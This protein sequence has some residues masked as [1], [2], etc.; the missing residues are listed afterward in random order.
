MVGP[1]D[2]HEVALR[3][4]LELDPMGDGLA[5]ATLATLPGNVRARLLYVRGREAGARGL[6]SQD[7]AVLAHRE[8]PDALC[9]CVCDGVGSSY[10]GGFAAQF[11]ARRIV[12]WL[13]VLDTLVPARAAATLARALDAWAGEAHLALPAV[14]PSVEDS[15]P[16]VREVL[17]E[18]RA[19]YGSETVF[20]AGRVDLKLR[21]GG[22]A[23]GRL[24]LL[25]LG[26]VAAHLLLPAG[27]V[28]VPAGGGGDANRWS[29]VRR[30]RGDVGAV[31]YA[32]AGPIRLVVHTDGAEGI[33][34]LVPALGDDALRE[35]VGRLQA[36]PTSDDATVL[37]IAWDPP[38]L[39][40]PPR[41]H[42]VVRR[43]PA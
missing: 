13:A 4:V 31:R 16:I 2:E 18:M 29:T 3:Q 26:N 24:L 6:P 41:T 19:E 23:P 33:G 35:W 20:L 36:P 15:G 42:E 22:A 17:D 8:A 37:D 21:G 11:L 30:V 5:C 25:W 40:H 38:S 7:Y 32:L 28:V 1:A 12:S 34:P 43:T 39:A 10:F 9:F 27:R 14:M